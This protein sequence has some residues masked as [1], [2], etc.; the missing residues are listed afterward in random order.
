MG[1][2]I[3][4]HGRPT[5]AEYYDA[6]WPS[7][8]NSHW[9]PWLQKQLILKDIFAAT[10]EVPLAYEPLW[11]RWVREVERF[12]ITSDTILVGHSCGAGFW[13]RYLSE[14]K[15]LRVGK[16]FLV[17]PWIDVEQDDPSGFFTFELDPNIAA[18]TNGLTIFH[19]SND[20]AEIQT[21][22]AKLRQKL[23]GIN[24]REFDDKGHFTHKYLPD[25]TFPELLEA[26]LGYSAT[27]A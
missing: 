2:A 10:P 24:Y 17:A 4:L 5:R 8:S 11:E 7:M 20:V 13:V 27:L 3:I 14:H 22:V 9:L 19:S 16:V 15:D 25:D 26:I 21:S 23:N 6:K 1:N 12:D 18:R